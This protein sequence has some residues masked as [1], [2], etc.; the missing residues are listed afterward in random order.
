MNVRFPINAVQDSIE[1]EVD[2]VVE[3]ATADEAMQIMGFLRSQA[4]RI[5]RRL[6]NPNHQWNRVNG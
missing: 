4:A 5:D 6:A 2:F 3:E 1:S